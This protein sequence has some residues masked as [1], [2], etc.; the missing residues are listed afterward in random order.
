ME[1]IIDGK[2]ITNKEELYTNLKAQI[3]SIEFFGNNLD[4]LWD[5]LST[6]DS[7]IIIHIKDFDE[8]KKNLGVYA[9]SLMQV[10]LDLQEINNKVR[11]L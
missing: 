3:N 8:L 2:K 7:E 6:I 9:D 10:F 11:I 5:I 1:I 4:A